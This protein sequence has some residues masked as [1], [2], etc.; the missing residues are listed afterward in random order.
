MY[1]KSNIKGITGSAVPEIK[2]LEKGGWRRVKGKIEK[3]YLW[4]LAKKLDL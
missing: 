2:M 3:K 4:L 1:L